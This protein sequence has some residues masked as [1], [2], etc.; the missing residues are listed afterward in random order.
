MLQIELIWLKQHGN[1]IRKIVFQIVHRTSGLFVTSLIWPSIESEALSA[2]GID[3]LGCGSSSV[4]QYCK[5]SSLIA[6]RVYTNNHY[7]TGSSPP[8]VNH[9]SFMSFLVGAR[10][11][12]GRV[13]GCGS[14]SSRD[15]CLVGYSACLMSS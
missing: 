13:N 7:H 2:M 8:R 14:S 12:A 15:L 1:C 10:G 9:L 11:L 6:S 5:E 3:S 4:T